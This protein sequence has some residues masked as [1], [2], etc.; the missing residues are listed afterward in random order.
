MRES[1]VK[2]RVEPGKRETDERRLC[3]VDRPSDRDHLFTGEG[4]GCEEPFERDGTI[5]R[6]RGEKR[7]VGRPDMHPVAP[8]RPDSSHD[9]NSVLEASNRKSK[10]G[11]GLRGWKICRLGSLV[12]FGLSRVGWSPEY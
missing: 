4:E 3:M 12:T 7:H 11:N 5:L 9:Q 8:R 10:P 6:S 2:K 1:S